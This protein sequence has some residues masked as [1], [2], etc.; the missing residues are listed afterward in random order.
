[1]A[2]P[3]VKFLRC[4]ADTLLPGVV[5]IEGLPYMPK[6]YPWR[7]LPAFKSKKKKKKRVIFPCRVFLD[8][9]TNE[10]NRSPRKA[11]AKK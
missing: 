1:M 3:F 4:S 9:G 6:Q 10:G 2:C 8:E 5:G 11:D 7:M